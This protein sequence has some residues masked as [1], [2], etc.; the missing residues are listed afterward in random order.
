MSL[1]TC[2]SCG[3]KHSIFG[4]GA[5]DQNAGNNSRS[6]VQ[7]ACTKHDIE[8]LG[9]L[10]LDARICE[11]ADRGKPTVVAEP[12]EAENVRAFRSLAERVGREI[13]L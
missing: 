13:G 11:D 2:P 3:S 4:T 7:H 8:L 9:E 6:N 1:F 10:P 5:A 12:W